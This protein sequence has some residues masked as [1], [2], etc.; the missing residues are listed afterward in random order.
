MRYFVQGLRSDV[1]ET[2]L[3]KQ[4]QTFREAQEMARLACDV[5]TTMYNFPQDSLSTQ[6]TN[7]TQT[8]NSLL[9]PSVSKAKQGFPSEGKQLMAMMEQNN[10]I[11]AELSDS[12]SQLRKPTSEPKV[13]FAS[14]NDTNQTSVATLA[15]PR[16]KSDIQELKELRAIEYLLIHKNLCTKRAKLCRTQAST[17]IPVKLFRQRKANVLV[18]EAPC[19]T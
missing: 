12:I 17:S 18:R 2:V 1:R 5:K 15:R 8:M 13:R 3:L 16:D 6:V 9:L 19:Q 14:Q 11:L 4:P 7:L 10:A